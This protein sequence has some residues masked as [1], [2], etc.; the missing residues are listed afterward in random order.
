VIDACS[1][2]RHS[3]SPIASSSSTRRAPGMGTR[4]LE[5]RRRISIALRRCR[6]FPRRPRSGAAMP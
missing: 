5:S 2:V 6:R 4:L 3:S 1:C